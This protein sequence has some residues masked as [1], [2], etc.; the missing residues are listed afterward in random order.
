MAFRLG[1]DL[2][3]ARTS[4]QTNQIFTRG[5]SDIIRIYLALRESSD[6]SEYTTAIF[7][8]IQRLASNNRVEENAPIVQQ[9]IFFD[10]L[11]FDTSWANFTIVEV[12]ALE[13]FSAKRIAYTAAALFWTSETD[14][15]LMATNRISRDLTS[16][17]AVL[18]SIV[19]SSIPTYL[20][21]PLAATLAPSV[22]SLMSSVHPS[23]RQKAIITFYHVCLH[24][25]E[26]IKAGVQILRARLDDED[27]SVVFSALSVIAELC[28]HNARNFVL[29]IPKIVKMLE[30]SRSNWTILKLVTV[31]RL[32]SVA[33]PRLPKK[34][35]TPFAGLIETT[36]SPT[37][38]FEVVKSVVEIPIS[39]GVL[40]TQASQRM[41][42]FLEHRDPNLRFLGLGL[43]MQ[44]LRLQPRLVAQHRDLITQSLDSNDDITRFLALDLLV[45][46]ATARSVDGIVNKITEHFRRSRSPLFK[47]QLVT[48]V[49]EICSRA[50]YAVV[51]D[52]D[53]YISVI[54][55]FVNEGGVTC[56]EL[57]ADQFLDLAT[58]VPATR[59]R[60]VR[61]LAVFLE[62]PQYS[63][64]TR[65]LLVAAHIIGEYGEGEAIN[66]VCRPA[67]VDLGERVQV[68]CLSAAFKIFL[69]APDISGPFVAKLQKFS[70][71]HHAE[72]QDIASV[73]KVIVGLLLE[74]DMEDALSD[75]I[76]RLTNNDESEEELP[77]IRKPAELDVP[78]D[79]FEPEPAEPISDVNVIHLDI[80][81]V[82]E[83]KP[84]R[85]RLAK[86]SVGAERAVVLKTTGVLRAKEDTVKPAVG[87][88]SSKL[89]KVDLTETVAAVEAQ[90]AVP[91][92][93][94]ISLQAKRR[95]E[96]EAAALAKRKEDS[97][98]GK[99]KRKEEKP[100]R[101]PVEGPIPG[102]RQQLLC[103]NEVFSVTAI[104]FTPQSPNLL[105]VDVLVKNRTG[106]ALGPI[107]ITRVGAQELAPIEEVPGNGSRTVALAL[108]LDNL[109]APK[110]VKLRFLAPG[111]DPLDGD[112]R[113][114]PSFFLAAAPVEELNDARELAIHSDE[115]DC[116]AKGDGRTVLQLVV[117]VLRGTILSGDERQAKIV[118]SRSVEGLPVVAT[119]DVGKNKVLVRLSTSNEALLAILVKEIQR[120]K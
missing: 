39:N 3:K 8:D 15:A 21:G 54:F 43:F 72:V 111:V 76:T 69:R 73:M 79:L 114:F 80:D 81:Y 57:L 68:A 48:K 84:K 55:D 94:D 14:A 38:L 85:K 91:L 63:E 82:P 88:L 119:V 44:L 98:K 78:V 31:L 13:D 97:A 89:A 109:L 19:L 49:V 34:L 64:E 41:A 66:I 87:A 95:A 75:L 23:I 36:S 101:P 32:L 67:I 116:T 51:Q 40:L 42:E 70:G 35:V 52:F 61:E 27:N 115:I 59:P 18:T 113:I 2:S 4:T 83:T 120:K 24:S 30:G 50:D 92:R 56:W 26:S 74:G 118:F 25:P 58:R 105:G 100:K 107:Q 22:I 104:E 28:A 29:M 11:G 7:Q 90:R 10:L 46:V 96:A 93:T 108:E 33:E 6:G 17:S 9:L 117:N 60:L 99:K 45:S 37:V 53:W 5:M 103:E 16:P 12:M 77:E 1:V 112:L 106:Q 86:Q 65:L 110:L 62:Q 102:W 47:N 20:G 71:S